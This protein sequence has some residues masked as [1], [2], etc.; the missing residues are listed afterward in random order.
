MNIESVIVIAAL[1]LGIIGGLIKAVVIY[2]YGAVW[3]K[4]Y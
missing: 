3:N 4:K 2:A 1:V